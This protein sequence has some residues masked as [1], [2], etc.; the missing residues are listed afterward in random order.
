MRSLASQWKSLATSRMA[1]RKRNSVLNSSRN[2]V[3][4]SSASVMENHRRSYE[5]CQW[6]SQPKGAHS[7]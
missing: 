7:V 1:N 2:M 4:A 6:R 3:M 5:C